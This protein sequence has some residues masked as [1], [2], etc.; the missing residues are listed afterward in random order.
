MAGL[1]A[2]AGLA[3]TPPPLVNYQGVLRN[4]SN[5]PLTGSYQMTFVF[6][7]AASGGD[8]IMIETHNGGIFNPLIQVTNGLFSVALGTGARTDGSGPGTIIS[9]ADVFRFYGDVWME[10]RIG[11]PAETLT[12]RAHILS[13]A[14]AEN[15]GALEGHQAS[16]FLDVT[17]TAQSKTGRLTVDDASSAPG[18]GMTIQS[19][20]TAAVF[21]AH[22][23]AS[24]QGWLGYGDVGVWGAGNYSG[25]FFQSRTATG[26]ALLG[27][28]NTGVQGDGKVTG[29]TFT[30]SDGHGFAYLGQ[31]GKGGSFYNSGTGYASLASG[32]YG[33]VASGT[34]P[35]GGGGNFTDPYY[36]GSATCALGDSGIVA[37]GTYQGGEFYDSNNSGHAHLG[38]GGIGVYG[39]GNQNED[40][41]KG[42]GGYFEDVSG[43][44]SAAVGQGSIGIS[45]TGTSVAG[46][47]SNTYGS[48]AYLPYYD[49][50]LYASGPTTGGYYSNFYSTFANLAYWNGSSAYTIQGN[51]A[52]SFVQ[53][54]PYDTGKSVV[55]VALEG[56]EAGT[57]TRGQG[58]LDGGVARVRLGPSFALVTNPDV[59]LTAHL[60]PRG[61][62][63]S[64]AID[65]LTTDELVVK[66]PEGAPDVTF[67]YE[68]FGLRL[69]FE[70]IPIVQ[71]RVDEAPLP[72]L[73]TAALDASKPGNDNAFGRFV[74]MRS[75]VGE[76]A[77]LDTTRSEALKA[78][79]G[80]GKEGPPKDR[81]GD[82]GRG[83]LPAPPRPETSGQGV[84]QA[85]SG[86]GTGAA[87][88][89]PGAA[90]G[91]A[92]G[93]AGA[94][95]APRSFPAGT[96]PVAVETEVH[97]GD[98]VA[99]RPGNGALAASTATADTD[100]IAL[101][102]IAG[103]DGSGWTGQAPLA[104]GGSVVRCRVEAS[105]GPIGV[106]DLLTVSA[107][108]GHA[109]R[110]TAGETVAIVAKALEP[111]A[112]GR[113]I[114]R[115]LALAR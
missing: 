69:G 6:Y 20:G 70:R 90:S 23:T 54:H 58:R 62:A 1:T 104:L 112:E 75:E 27:Y 60:T 15:A 77:P 72:A 89:Q 29:G 16:E 86:G 101:G 48:A 9:L 21:G 30:Q 115:V 45:A 113:G 105:G 42:G 63:V 99:L 43:A 10:I 40:F 81:H 44:A 49:T 31:N 61:G 26:S 96:A 11:S 7:S 85:G 55:F 88:S 87:P 91:P 74:A 56:D 18:N 79:I 37:S 107:V 103:E 8:E 3:A 13:A 95:P 33:I 94:P 32:D 66:G 46:Q 5:V 22:K 38:F 114:I 36:S 71:P 24:G 109:R 47:F 4:A 59:G 108:P 25:G 41:Q 68:V 39:V 35:N 97:G 64:L 14:Y 52:K 78:A 57:Y 2:P 28:G 106:G 12:P 111:L 100:G 84:A 110:A 65:S 83:H 82:P 93:V 80:V 50:G 34:W 67:D 51:G 19:A 76:T 73:A 17:S 53:N 98:V 92:Q 102:I